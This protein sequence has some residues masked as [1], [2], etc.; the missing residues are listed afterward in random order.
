MAMVVLF[1]TIPLMVL[2]VAAAVAPLLVAMARDRRAASSPV[3]TAVA[4]ASAPHHPHP[5]AAPTGAA[6]VDGQAAPAGR[7]RVLAGV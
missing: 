2:G 1:L 3:A 5:P 4:T 7:P 6:V